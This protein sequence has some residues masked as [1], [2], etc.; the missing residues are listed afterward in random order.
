MN[1][2]IYG[3][4]GI[5]GR[6]TLNLIDQNFPNLK[7]NLLCAKSNLKLLTQQIIKYKPKYAFLYDSEKLLKF[8]YKIGKTQFLNLNELHGYLKSSKSNLTLLAISGYKSLYFLESIIENTDH[9]GIVSK[10]A[11]VSAGHIFRKRKYFKK[12]NVIPLDSEHFSLFELF[13][14]MNINN[15][16]NK[17]VLTAS[18]G[19]FYKKKFNS[20]KNIKF[21]QAIKHPMWKMGYKNSIDSATLVNKCLELVEAHYLFNIPFKKMSILI[22]PQAQVHSIVEFEN[23]VTQL[24]LFKNDMNIPILNFLLLTKLKNCKNNNN[25]FVNDYN[26]LNFENVK[27]EVFPIYKFFNKIDKNRPENLIKFNIGNEYAVNLYKNGIIK[28]TDI[29]KIIK[30]VTY[31]NLY[32]SV[33]TIKDILNYHEEVEKKLQNFKNFNI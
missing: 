26:S 22:H 4:T 20:L 18:G 25:Y 1:I 32:S 5:I 19:P 16:I 3:S 29:Y 13:N 10:E 23:Y 15:N 17:I 30:K 6:K 2:N 14:K 27:N 31:L 24:N 9:L 7:V 11:I 21:T 8:D 33:N 28:Y 12:T